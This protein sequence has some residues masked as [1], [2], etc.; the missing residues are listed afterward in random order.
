MVY[1][2]CFCT[3]VSFISLMQS[4]FLHVHALDIQPSNVH[5]WIFWLQW[6]LSTEDT[7]GISWCVRGRLVY[8]VHPRLSEP[9]LSESLLSSKNVTSSSLYLSMSI[10]A[11]RPG[12]AG[13]VPEFWPLSWWCLSWGKIPKMS[14]NLCAPCTFTHLYRWSLK[15]QAYLV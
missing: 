14:Q 7:I 10:V 4:T 6:D 8:T 9:R 2:A 15:P 12:M 13:T 3:L 11:N 1:H 5:C